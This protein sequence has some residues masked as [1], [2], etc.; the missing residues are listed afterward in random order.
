[1]KKKNTWISIVITIVVVG[2]FSLI[3]YFITQETDKA[4]LVKENDEFKLD[5]ISYQIPVGF[6]YS[7]TID[8]SYRNYYYSEDNAYCHIDIERYS[9]EYN[10]SETGEDYLKRSL[11]I[12]LG[13]EVETKKEGDWF[14]VQIKETDKTI[15]K[16]ASIKH[17][18]AIY[19]IDYKFNDYINGENEDTKGYTTCLNAF[20]FVYNSIE[21]EK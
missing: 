8:E 15:R 13:D 5:K 19:T 3:P 6:E 1:M 16:V 20:D 21:F 9:S 4:K 7:K 14:I 18:K 12:A 17:K 2:L 10:E 11:Y